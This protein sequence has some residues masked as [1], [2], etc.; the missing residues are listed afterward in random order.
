[1]VGV[2]TMG[3]RQTFGPLV[4]SYARWS[5]DLHRSRK[6]QKTRL[7]NPKSIARVS[8]FRSPRLSCRAT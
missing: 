1:M 4:F 2:A 6:D 7:G 5:V 8:R 3:K